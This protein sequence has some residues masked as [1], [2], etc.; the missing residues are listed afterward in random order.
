MNKTYR[1]YALNQ[2]LLLPPNLRDW[3]PEGH[4]ALFLLDVVGAM[5]LTPIYRGY[6]AG[7][8]R[9][10]PPYHPGMMVAL[11]LYGYCTGK[12][13]SRK[14]ERATYE[15]VPYRVLTGDQHPDH[16]S[17]AEFRKRNLTA[18]A[19]LFVEVLRLCE[20]AGLVSLGHVSLDGTKVKA[21]ASKHKAMSYERMTET[22]KRLTAE[23]ESLLAK[24]EEVDAA[25]DAEYGPTLRGDELPSELARRESRL[26]KIREAKAAL[27]EEAKEKAK[28][29]AAQ[30][31]EKLEER[32][33]KE[34][35]TG[36]KGGGRAPKVPEPEEAIPEP[37]AQRNFTDPESRI[38]KDGASK[39]FEQAYN[40]Q[41]VV[42]STAQVI[43]ASAVTQ[44][45]NDKKQLIPM[46]EKVRGNA[47]RLPD[48]V[49]ADAGYFSEANATASTLTGVDLYV[50][51]DR[52]K[53]GETHD[54]AVGPPPLD[55]TVIDKMRHK[56][57][58]TEGRATYK[59]RKQ[60]VEPVFGQIKEARGFRRFS[61]RGISKVRAEWDLICLT[62]NLLK[63]FRA[64]I[65][66]Q[67]AS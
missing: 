24:A 7:D 58:T 53:H 55:A 45:T 49:S 30:A 20:K 28:R 36:K 57:R 11:L 32:E 16:S 64:G 46:L 65:C 67:T 3:V 50:P 66:L 14:I 1:P 44:E 33:R 6:E 8:G 40:A 60:V 42:D 25:E 19:G 39:S 21:N 47:G 52:Q 13:S 61:F 56:L 22:E 10:Q 59:M 4:V 35:E 43:V 29:A 9:G 37:K 18:L 26:K 27:E 17:I 51:P 15:E 63:L 41:A 48:K 34:E 62:H 38:M 23:V 54:R 31:R 2:Q 12:A 5:D